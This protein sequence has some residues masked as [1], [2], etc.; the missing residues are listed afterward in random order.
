MAPSDHVTDLEM[1]GDD[2]SERTPGRKTSREQAFGEKDKGGR[3]V[4]SKKRARHQE[5]KPKY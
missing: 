1:A 5:E 3:E 4:N 2:A